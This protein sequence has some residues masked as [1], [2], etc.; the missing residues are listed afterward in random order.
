MK[1]DNQLETSHYIMHVL[2]PD[3]LDS[4]TAT[5]GHLIYLFVV[6]LLIYL[7]LFVWQN[8]DT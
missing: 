5:E 1:E 6:L 8:S 2:I 7:I 3:H 4:G